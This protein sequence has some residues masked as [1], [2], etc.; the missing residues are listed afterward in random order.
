MHLA[1][2][3]LVAHGVETFEGVDWDGQTASGRRGE[4]MA[5]KFV[6]WVEGVCVNCPAVECGWEEGQRWRRCEGSSRGWEH[7]V[8]DCT[9]PDLDSRSAGISRGWPAVSLK[10]SDAGERWV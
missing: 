9:F 6:G 8:R 5:W 10:A 2:D 1:F 7:D 4:D 3:F